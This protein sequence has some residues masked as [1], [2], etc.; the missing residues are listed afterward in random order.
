MTDPFAVRRIAG[1][2]DVYTDDDTLTDAEAE[3]AA[4]E[5]MVARRAHDR[6]VLVAE[7][8]ACRAGFGSLADSILRL[9]AAPF[10]ADICLRHVDRISATLKEVSR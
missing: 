4:L 9:N 5:S 10:L 7:L 2:Y 1:G 8:S 3:R 6:V